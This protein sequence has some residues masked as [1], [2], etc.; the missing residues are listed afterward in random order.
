MNKKRLMTF[1]FGAG[2]I[3]MLR[4]FGESEFERRS[5]NET[6][7]IIPPTNN[8]CQGGGGLS[9]ALTADENRS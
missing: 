8:D 4:M 1:K 3:D 9:I 7:S 5:R 2:K 6:I